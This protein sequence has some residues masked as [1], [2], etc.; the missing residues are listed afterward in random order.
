VKL[1]KWFDTLPIALVPVALILGI[2]FGIQF[3]TGQYPDDMIGKAV[4][5]LVGGWI[6]IMVIWW[7]LDVVAGGLIEQLDT[8][9]TSEPNE[10]APGELVMLLMRD[11]EVVQEVRSWDKPLDRG[12]RMFWQKRLP[13]ILTRRAKPTESS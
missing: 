8:E 4:S 9:S 5:A 2:G 1:G 3:S 12:R 10:G 7:L 13:K 6:G 11:G